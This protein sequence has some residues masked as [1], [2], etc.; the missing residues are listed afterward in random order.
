MYGKVLKSEVVAAEVP[1]R[2]CQLQT[3]AMALL[4]TVWLYCFVVGS[5]VLRMLKCWVG[6]LAF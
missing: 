5:I 3:A 2:L 1:W 4:V 6:Y